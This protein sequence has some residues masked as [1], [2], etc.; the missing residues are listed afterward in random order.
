MLSDAKTK[1]TQFHRAA[2]VRVGHQ[3]V[4]WAITA[5]VSAE[6]GC[7]SEKGMRK[8]FHDLNNV[9]LSRWNVSL[10]PN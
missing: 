3:K 10:L 5:Q 1:S 4:M 7:R 9:Q 2:L 6:I 8:H